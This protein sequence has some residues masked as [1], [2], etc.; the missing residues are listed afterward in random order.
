MDTVINNDAHSL[1]TYTF[2]AFLRILVLAPHPDDFDAI[3]ITMRFFRENGNQI[4]LAV[5]TTGANGVEDDFCSSSSL[6]TKIHV[7]EREQRASSKFFGLPESNLAFL[8]LE[9]NETG[10]VLKN[11]ANIA[12]VR[13]HFLSK[14]P[15]IVFLPH[16]NDTNQAHQSVYAIFRKVALESEKPVVIFLNR[17]P[18]TIQ[19]QC[20]VYLGFGETGAAWKAEL[21][22][23]HQSQQQRNLNQRGHGIDDRILRMDQQSAKACSANS[24]Y[25]EIY[26]LELFRASNLRDILR[27]SQ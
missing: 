2:P 18:K 27:L 14:Q 24:P 16:W 5:A 22:R 19:M 20:N 25:A 23:F 10:Q 13:R 15:V 3:G 1:H 8:R 21:L 7:R 17:D 4:Y 9:K 12:Q 26:E 6:E 11:K